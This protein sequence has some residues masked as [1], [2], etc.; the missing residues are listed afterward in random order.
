MAGTFVGNLLRG[1]KGGLPGAI[2]SGATS[3]IGN[4]G[5]RRRQQQA[6][7]QNIEFWK[8]Q[9]AYNTPKMQMQRLPVLIFTL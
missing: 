9:N 7:Q 3:L 8:M 2:L 5:A 6:D 1:L 4:R